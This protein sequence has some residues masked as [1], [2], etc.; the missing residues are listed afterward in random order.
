MEFGYSGQIWLSGR[1]PLYRGLTVY[2]H[3]VITKHTILN[4]YTIHNK[5]PVTSGWCTSETTSETIL[6]HYQDKEQFVCSEGQY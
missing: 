2:R 1:V 3:Y 6:R 4:V 5:L